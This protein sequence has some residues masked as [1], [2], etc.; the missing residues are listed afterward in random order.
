MRTAFCF[1][2]DGTVTQEEILPLLAREL[3]IFDEIQ[4]LTLAT[5]NGAIPFDSSFKLRVKIL[6]TIPIARVRKIISGVMLHTRIV[7][8]MRLNATQCFLITGNLD[9]WLLDL[10]NV[11]GIAAYTSIARHDGDQLLGV[12][13]ILNKGEAV[14]NVRC[15]GFDRVIAVGD[16]MGDVPMFLR[17]DVRIAFGGV[18]HPIK[19]LKEL[20]D[21]VVFTEEALC[22][23]LNT[24]L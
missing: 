22:R 9:V 24:L 15:K 7:E 11:L 13:S 23:T 19:T 21:F 10:L 2:L 1:D 17:A 12:A 18:H 4:A 16:G 14:D 20:S 8:F 5:I 3:D 6:S